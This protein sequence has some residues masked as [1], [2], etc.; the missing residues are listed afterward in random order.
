[1]GEHDHEYP[2]GALA[3]DDRDL[4]D[5]RPVD[6]RLLARQRFGAHERFGARPGADGGH[7]P[8]QRPQ[9]SGVAALA[10]HVVEA[11]RDQAR[12]ALQ[13]FVDEVL[14]GIECTAPGAALTLPA[15]RPDGT[16]DDIGVDAELGRNRALLPMLGEKQAPDLRFAGAVDHRR[17]P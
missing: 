5:M 2:Q 4:A 17:P 10:D 13:R 11:R 1:M 9:T 14:V 3:A 8:T 7:I 16:L 6:L 12:V 15:Q